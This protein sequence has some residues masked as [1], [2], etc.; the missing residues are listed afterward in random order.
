[1][2]AQRKSPIQNFVKSVLVMKANDSYG[3]RK[4]YSSV[5]KF[6]FES[7]LETILY[8]QISGGESVGYMREG[9]LTAGGEDASRKVKVWKSV[10]IPKLFSL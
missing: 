5:A 7:E 8:R 6:P 1:M 3:S 2:A 10:V 9:V 4:S